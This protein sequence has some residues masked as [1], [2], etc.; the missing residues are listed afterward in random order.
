[1][2]A[3][4]LHALREELNAIE[5]HYET[6]F[7][8]TQLEVAVGAERALVQDMEGKVEAIRRLLGLP[9]QDDEEPSSSFSSTHSIDEDPDASVEKLKV[10]GPKRPVNPD[11]PFLCPK[12]GQDFSEFK[13]L[14]RHR[15]KTGHGGSSYSCPKCGE[16]FRREVDMKRHQT[17][18][19]HL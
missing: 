16:G 6:K 7:Q 17:K 9:E 8:I 10:R 5:D 19:E 11:R 2:E 18:E 13:Y 4:D 15:N 3:P 1:M 14:T 12:C